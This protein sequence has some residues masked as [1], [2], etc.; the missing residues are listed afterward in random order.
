MKRILC[1]A[2]LL[3]LWI[4]A[5]LSETEFS[6]S[7]K[8]E[9]RLSMIKRGNFTLLGTITLSDQA[10]YIDSVIFDERRAAEEYRRRYTPSA[11]ETQIP[12]SDIVRPSVFSKLSSGE[13]TLKL[14]C[15]RNEAE[16]CALEIR[17]TVLGKVSPLA[18]ITKKC[19]FETIQNPSYLTNGSYY[20]KYSWRP[21]EKE[22]T[23]IIQLPQGA[24]AAMLEVE[25]YT[26]PKSGGFVLE[27]LN[28]SGECILR[29]TADENYRMLSDS[30]PLDETASSIRI[31]VT[32][33]TTCINAVHIYAE[34]GPLSQAQNWQPMPEKL[35]ILHISTHQ[36]DELLFFGGSIPYHAALGY[37]TGVLYMV[38]CGRDRLAEALSGLWAAG[39]K[40]HP[41]F[42]DFMDSVPE[43]YE[44]AL[45]QWNG[46]DYTV[47]RMVEEIRRLKPDVIVT[48]GEDGEYGHQHHI[49]TSEAA[50]IACRA[51]ADPEMY[52]ASYEKY[53]AWQV[54][55][56]YRHQSFGD[57]V[58]RMNWETPMEALD[59]RT[60][61]EMSEIAYNRHLSQIS[62][63]PYSFAKP[64]DSSAFALVYSIVGADIIGG[65]FFENITP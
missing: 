32:D 14:L 55:K 29:E 6:V 48:H 28:A 4:P 52:P 62:Y 22:D 63:L 30:F 19:T 37:D 61:I 33:Y 46:M 35:D 5:S 39:L 38:D 20:P 42:L 53:G 50:F 27:V 21:S 7:V 43:S 15:G 64:Y 17:F 13:K 58:T 12:L 45:S 16:L 1:I 65:D 11:G 47:E 23:L 3:L 9:N 31:R 49:V 44:Q 8:C 26:P 25:W 59:G 57:H 34:N 54:Q 18:E 24:N 36:D 56:L 40:T 2:L 51:A 10:D 41:V 60:P